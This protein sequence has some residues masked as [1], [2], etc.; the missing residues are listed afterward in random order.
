MLRIVIAV[1]LIL[2]LFGNAFLKSAIFIDFKIN[3]EFIVETLCIQKD[4]ANNTCNGQCHLTQQFEKADESS[5]ELPATLTEIQEVILYF[6]CAEAIILETNE[7]LGI[8]NPVISTLVP[9]EETCSIFHPPQ[10]I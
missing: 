1:S 10:L 4:E 6:N 5:D 2:T 7:V 3:Q 9:S 8:K